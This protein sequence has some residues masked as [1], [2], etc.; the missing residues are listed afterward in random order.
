MI[1]REIADRIDELAKG[2]THVPLAGITQSKLVELAGKVRWTRDGWPFDEMNSQMCK[3]QGV[4]A[5]RDETIRTLHDVL[6][7]TQK[8]RDLAR[9]EAFDARAAL[10]KAP[11][12]E[13]GE[14]K[15]AL[16]KQLESI[17]SFA[18]ARPSPVPGDAWSRL[19]M[20]AA[21]VGRLLGSLE[22]PAGATP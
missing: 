10:D 2:L 4:L 17:E 3:L 20:I 5:E 7:R 11:K 16:I 1:N 18:T 19:A 13:R 22:P 21:K 12:P 6:A 8:E 14:D 9:A 15:P